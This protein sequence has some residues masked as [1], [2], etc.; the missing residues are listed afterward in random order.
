[1][2]AALALKFVVSVALLLAGAGLFSIPIATLVG[3]VLQR[4]LARKRCLELLKQEPSTQVRI[5][6]DLRIM[7]PNT[8]RM[9]V[10]MVSSYLTVNANMAICL[11]SFGLVANGRYGLSV[12]LMSIA[13][14][15]ASV[16]TLTKWPLISQHQARHESDQVQ[17]IL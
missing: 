2:V 10:H 1:M 9:G 11:Y 3:C 5:K 7:W 4:H 17:R 8:W 14:G 15:M 13:A 6:D 16:W 12:Q